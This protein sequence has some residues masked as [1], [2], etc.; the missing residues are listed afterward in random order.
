MN[1]LMFFDILARARAGQDLTPA[2]RAFIKQ[3][4]GT[5]ISI[6]VTAAT[7]AFP[8]LSG[9]TIDWSNVLHVF[10]ASLSTSIF[11]TLSKYFT[12]Q[13]DAPQNPAPAQPATSQP[14]ASPVSGGAG[15]PPPGQPAPGSPLAMAVPLPRSQ[16]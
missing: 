7:A 2:E 5:V 4:Q 3:L 15:F 14:V 11:F 13:G 10:L 8:Y 16:R 9:Q 6:L 12:A 1:P